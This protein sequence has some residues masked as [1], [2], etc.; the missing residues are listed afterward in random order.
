METVLKHW[1][2]MTFFDGHASI[3]PH[4]LALGSSAFGRGSALWPIA[5]TLAN[6]K[7]RTKI[8]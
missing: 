7:C 3:A 5:W 1:V 4:C 8:V 2:A 6:L